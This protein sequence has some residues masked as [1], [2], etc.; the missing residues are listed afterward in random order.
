[1]LARIL[2]SARKLLLRPAV[3]R[4]LPPV[5]TASIGTTI[6]SKDTGSYMDCSGNLI[7]FAGTNA[8]RRGYPPPE[9]ESDI[10][11]PLQQWESEMKFMMSREDWYHYRQTGEWWG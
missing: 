10:G 2:P 6:Y 9:E 3:R 8:D 5:L 11:T 1:M 7:H 4:S